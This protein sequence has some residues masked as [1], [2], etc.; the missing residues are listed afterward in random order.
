MSLTTVPHLLRALSSEPLAIEPRTLRAFL[1]VLRQRG[2]GASF[3][4]MGLHA[5]MG[6]PMPRPQHEAADGRIAVIP[7]VGLISNRA[8]SLGTGADRIGAMV[9][10]A[11]KSARVDGI[12]FDIDSPGG[13]VTGVPELADKIYEAGKIKPTV[14]V[15]NGLMASAAYWAGSAANKVVVTPSGE[16]GSIGVY[17]LHED[18]T[19]AMEADGVK[20]TEISAGKYK[21]EGAPWKPL[22]EEA[23]SYLQGRVTAAYDWFVK[24]VARFRGDTPAAVR[25]GYGEGRVLTAKD[26]VAA[27]LADRVGTL[28]ETVARMAE[29]TASRRER[30][31]AMDARKRARMRG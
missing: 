12:V 22:D 24:D 6:V 13:T 20:I 7:I 31:A 18:W 16:P 14:S 5:E 11:V 1:S 10:A 21:T 19:A 4:G 3:T 25:K 27:K 15:A 17:L 2:D 8:Q 9:D 26:A 23:E 28:S 29:E 30:D